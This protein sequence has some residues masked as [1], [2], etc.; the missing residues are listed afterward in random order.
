MEASSGQHVLVGADRPFFTVRESLD[1]IK[2]LRQLTDPY[3]H[4][5]AW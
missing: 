5:E 2:S 4:R 3:R 1:D